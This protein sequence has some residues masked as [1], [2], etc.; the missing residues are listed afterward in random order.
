MDKNLVSVLIM[1]RNES[2]HISRCVESARCVADDIYVV[3]SH[4]TDET[5]QIAAKLG[6]RVMSGDFNSFSEKFNWALNNINFRTP[7]VVRLDAD[8]VLSKDLID[9]LHAFLSAQPADISGAYVRRQLWFMGRWVR[10]GGMYPTYSMRIWRA[11]LV[12]CE[13]RELDEHMILKSGRAV[14][15]KADVIDNPLTDLSL[16]IEKHN[17]YA[18]R[19]ARAALGGLQK[20]DKSRGL[21]SLTGALPQ[22][23]RWIKENIFYKLPPFVRPCLYFAYRYIFRLG[24]LDGKTGFIFH[25]M[26]ALWYRLLV[27]AKIIEIK[28]SANR[29]S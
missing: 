17:S 8:E 14:Y 27:D 21:A 10:F 1:T 9:E 25:F 13:T 11:G 23:V 4:S 5:T 18:G 20:G 28:I 19:E 7:W 22:R 15:F 2:L 29:R 24:F 6:V 26:H 12:E 3:D 16:W